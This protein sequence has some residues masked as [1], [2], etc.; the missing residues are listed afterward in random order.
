LDGLVSRDNPLQNDLDHI[1]AQTAPIW[2]SLRGKRIFITG[3]TGFFGRWLL[4]SIHEANRQLGL[5]LSA[6]VLSRDPAAFLATANNLAEASWLTFYQGDVRSFEF[7]TERFTHLIHAATTTA[8]ETFMNE[9]PLEKFATVVEGT[10]RVM[11]FAKQAGVEDMLLTSSGVVYG[12]QPPEVTH[13][14]EEHPC[15]PDPLN[16]RDALGVSKLAS[17]FICFAMGQQH[18][19][20]V[21][22]ARCFSFVG[23]HL[24]MRVHYAIGNFIR[25]AIEGKPITIHGDGTPIRS[26]LYASDLMIWL[27]TIFQRGLPGRA[28]NV[29]SGN[30]ISI[31]KLARIVAQNSEIN[32]EVILKGQSGHGSTNRYVPSV[33]RAER[34]LGL[35]QTMTLPESILK[36]IAF[37]KRNPIS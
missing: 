11:V 7:P 8:T 32:S 13:L 2:E 3:G 27:F 28:Y 19:I 22:V 29:G 37:Y 25:D 36:T 34:E 23:P 5:D 24:Q 17:E 31:E 14:S 30:A 16:P 18:G 35:R 9:P 20:R 10:R 26:Y 12:K 1:V 4:E 21:R 15:A 6:M 33:L